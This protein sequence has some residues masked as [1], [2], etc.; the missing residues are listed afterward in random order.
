MIASNQAGVA[1]FPLGVWITTPPNGIISLLGG[2]LLVLSSDA[3]IAIHYT[4]HKP[5]ANQFSLARPYQQPAPADHFPGDQTILTAPSDVIAPII[6]TDVPV[7]GKFGSPSH[8]E[9][10][11]G[12]TRD[13]SSQQGDDND[14]NAL[15]TLPRVRRKRKRGLARGLNVAERQVRERRSPNVVDSSMCISIASECQILDC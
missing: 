8:D 7:A 15:I 9:P 5:A 2:R 4:D 13:A 10:P 11:F 12:S 3:E 6:P 14:G 1:P